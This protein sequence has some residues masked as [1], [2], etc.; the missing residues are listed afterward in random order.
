METANACALRAGR[1]QNALCVLRAILA[2]P[3]LLAP[4]VC[5]AHVSRV[6]MAQARARARARG[7]VLS[8]T[9]AHPDIGEAH[10]LLAPTVLMARAVKD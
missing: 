9:N 10:V 7:R 1:E 8:A 2:P 6:A 4:T 3:A 5:M